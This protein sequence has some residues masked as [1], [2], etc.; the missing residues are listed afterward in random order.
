MGWA[1]PGWG[2][3]RTDP[4]PLLHPCH[5]PASTA[6]GWHS[7]GKPGPSPGKI[8][9]CLTDIPDCISESC[10]LTRRNINCFLMNFIKTREK[11]RK[12]KSN[13]HVSW[14]RKL[15]LFRRS[16]CPGRFQV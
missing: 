15:L 13:L 7:Q 9:L 4:D 10:M 8:H 3:T 16:G 5:G 11:S 12:L 1:R 6:A 2:H 14:S